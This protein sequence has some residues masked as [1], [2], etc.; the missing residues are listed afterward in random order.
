M[1]IVSP[2]P[3]LIASLTHEEASRMGPSK[4]IAW[5]RQSLNVGYRV[6]MLID[7]TFRSDPLIMRDTRWDL[8]L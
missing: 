5:R 7:Y 1:C 4:A 2:K 6:S 3:Q 8:T